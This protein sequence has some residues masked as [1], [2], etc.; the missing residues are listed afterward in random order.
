MTYNVKALGLLAN[1]HS[2][3]RGQGAKS[4]LVIVTLAA[5]ISE[6]IPDSAVQCIASNHIT[7]H[8]V[9]FNDN[10]R[11]ESFF[12]N[13]LSPRHLPNETGRK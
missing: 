4:V 3:A 5:P 2:H 8:I 13:R 6:G 9:F 12:Q 1:E 10:K 11:P 7:C